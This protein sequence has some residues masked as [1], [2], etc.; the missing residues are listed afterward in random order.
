[1]HVH[2][3]ANGGR[4]L[5]APIA[6]RCYKCYKELDSATAIRCDRCL[7]T[8]FCST[9]CQR[10]GSVSHEVSC[11]RDRP[12]AAAVPPLPDDSPSEHEDNGSDDEVDDEYDQ[13][14]DEPPELLGLY[15]D[16][17]LG[18][19]SE[20]EN[21]PYD[22]E[23]NEEAADGEEDEYD[24]DAEADGDDDDGAPREDEAGDAGG[25]GG[26]GHH[27]HPAGMSHEAY[28]AIM[29]A[30]NTDEASHYEVRMLGARGLTRIA[31]LRARVCRVCARGR[32]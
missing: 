25:Q 9:T 27:P 12:L 10:G 29:T 32:A 26:N 7:T 28:A 30:L 22:E 2:A 6:E 18:G 24:E 15:N 13:P 4:H 21:E 20:S 3:H 14:V 8:A 19:Y 31:G 1:M 23:E 16:D 11:A 17:F 5:Q